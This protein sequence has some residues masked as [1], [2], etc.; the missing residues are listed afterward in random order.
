LVASLNEPV[1]DSNGAVAFKFTMRGSGITAATKTGLALDNGVS[2]DL[3]ARTGIG[4]A[5]GTSS[6][7]FATLSDPVLAP[8]TASAD[9]VAFIGTL[10]RSVGDTTRT[11]TNDQGIWSSANA[12]H[13][14]ELFVR[15]GDAAPGGGLFS[16]F[17]QVALTDNGTIIFTAT[18]SGLPASANQGIYYGYG[19]KTFLVA[20]TGA[21]VIVGTSVKTIKTLKFFPVSR[22]SMGQTRSFSHSA[23]HL[24][25]T[26]FFTDGTWGYYVVHF[27]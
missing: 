27:T 8:N 22:F 19:A 2:L 21:N 1:V 24:V 3:L 10:V 15:K 14:V 18:L 11:G 16:S 17:N 12:G 9:A 6:A 13:T 4:T 20:R 5:P 23:D 26:V 7:L 25:Y